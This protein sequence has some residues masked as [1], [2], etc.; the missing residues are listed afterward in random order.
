MVVRVE[1][2]DCRN[3][4]INGLRGLVVNHTED[5]ISL[6]TETGR[7]LTIPIDSCRYYVWFENCTRLMTHRE[8]RRLIRRLPSS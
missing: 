6:L 4:N 7:V 5:T 8:L 1:L 3:S 2:I